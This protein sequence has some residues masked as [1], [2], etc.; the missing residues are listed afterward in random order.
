MKLDDPALSS[1]AWLV[2][3]VREALAAL[4]AT[5]LAAFP[6]E[7]PDGKLD[8]LLIATD[9]GLVEGTLTGPP[10]E[11]MPGLVLDLRL[12]RDVVV[13]ARA[14][15]DTQH[16]AHAA[17]LILTIGDRTVTSYELRTRDAAEAFI[18]EVLQL[19]SRRA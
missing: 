18:V 17:R 13:S 15:V 3:A 14:R 4:H 19:A 12:W 8:R 9:L 2:D 1:H 7:S 11:G 16:G 10:I 6:V 5:E